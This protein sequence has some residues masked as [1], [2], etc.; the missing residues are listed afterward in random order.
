MEVKPQPYRMN[1]LPRH[2][3]FDS[4]PHVLQQRHRFPTESLYGFWS[5]YCYV[6]GWSSTEALEHFGSNQLHRNLLA[7]DD[8]RPMTLPSGGQIRNDSYEALSWPAT[9]FCISGTIRFCERCWSFGAHSDLFQHLAEERCPVHGVRLSTCCPQCQAPLSTTLKSCL[10][11]PYG[12]QACG[13]LFLTRLNAFR[14]SEE[15]TL[16]MLL[17]ADRLRDLCRIGTSFLSD[18]LVRQGLRRRGELL[19]KQFVGHQG[20]ASRSRLVRRHTVWSE[21]AQP[22]WAIGHPV[23]VEMRLDDWDETAPFRRER[24]SM[25]AETAS[26]TLQWLAQVC[27]HC[28][29]DGRRLRLLLGLNPQCL[30]VDARVSVIAVA[31]HSVMCAYGQSAW[32]IEE[33][34]HNPYT[35]IVFAARRFSRNPS[36]SAEAQ[37]LLVHFELLAAFAATLLVAAKEKRSRDLRWPVDVSALDYRPAWVVSKPAEGAVPMLRCRPRIT[38]RLVLRLI[39]RYRGLHLEGERWKSLRGGR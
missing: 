21:P 3:D 11:F 33:P 10:L 17:F 20:A 32:P 7:R 36:Q 1:A 28:W 15:V 18:G 30:F 35:N 38:R 6:T 23:E 34:E 29:S 37:A 24:E 2:V 12:C 19:T 5:R 25:V 8:H 31:L 13:H 4:P 39:V 16:C 26:A 27:H 14:A 22:R 9:A